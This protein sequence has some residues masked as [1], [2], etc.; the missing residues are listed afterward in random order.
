ME[1]IYDNGPPYIRFYMFHLADIRALFLDYYKPVEFRGIICSYKLLIF[2][3]S[4][5]IVLKAAKI[6]VLKYYECGR[7]NMMFLKSRIPSAQLAHVA[8]L[9]D[10]CASPRSNKPARHCGTGT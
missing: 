1:R 7:I 3:N 2:N 4:V 8:S 10:Y 5:V 6:T 9:R